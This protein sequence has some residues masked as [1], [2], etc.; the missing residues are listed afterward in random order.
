[1]HA[2]SQMQLKNRKACSINACLSTVNYPNRVEFDAADVFGGIAMKSNAT[3]RT[4]N[5]NPII[6]IAKVFGVNLE[7]D[8]T[9]NLEHVSKAIQIKTNG[10]ISCLTFPK[11]RDTIPASMR[12]TYTVQAF[13][14]YSLLLATGIKHVDFLSLDV[15]GAE[16]DILNTIPWD[17]VDI[18]LVMVEVDGFIISNPN[19]V[20]PGG[21]F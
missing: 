20:N 13:P 5:K 1:M 21:T 11:M 15:E 8:K 18:D 17:K 6:E 7:L 2:F 9:S 10:M 16:L 12:S 14:L 3:E 19:N 4:K